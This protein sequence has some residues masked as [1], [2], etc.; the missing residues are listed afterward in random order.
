MNQS[1]YS[2][3]RL[4]WVIVGFAVAVLVV[5]IIAVLTLTNVKQEAAVEPL[6]SQAPRVATKD[7]VKQNLALLSASLKQTETDQAAAKAAYADD[8]K[9]IKLGD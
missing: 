2:S 9:R 1:Q 7:E 4:L 6:P 5:S 8:K 3:R